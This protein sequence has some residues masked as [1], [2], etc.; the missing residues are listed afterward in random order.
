MRNSVKIT[1][2]PAWL[3]AP[4]VR[5]IFDALGAPEVD[6]RAVGGAV[7]DTVMGRDRVDSEIDIA[8]PEVPDE[9]IARLQSAKLKVVPTGLSHGTV[10]AVVNG[11][12]FE[13]TSLRR[14]TATDGR[15]AVVEFTEDWHEDARRRDFTFNA[16][17]MDAD[18]VVHDDH[19]GVEDAKAGRVRFVGNASD[20]IQEDYLRVLR[21]FRFQALYGRAPIDAE[22]LAACGAN[23]G[24]L[25]HLSAERVQAELAKML[26]APSPYESVAQMQA[27]GV[28]RAVLPVRDDAQRFARLQ[29]IERDAAIADH[30]WLRRLAALIAPDDAD[31]VADHLKLS[32]AD[33]ALLL[34]LCAPA[35][36][37]GPETPPA[38]RARALHELGAALV[39]DRAL[40]AWAAQPNPSAESWRALLAAIAGWTPKPLPVGGA[41]VLALG[42]TPGPRVGA[43]LEEMLA[44][45]LAQDRAPDRA[46]ALAE[47]K[48]RLSKQ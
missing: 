35:P 47:L 42:V 17:S 28:L 27:T 4:E 34:R 14:D 16:M 15:H 43:V 3:Q 40:L 5:R 32:N 9:V 38:V 1:L 33:R 45:W 8:T 36:I 6:V 39:R 48:S 22:T 13:I 7:R 26:G 24:G 19:G 31:P 44:W 25:A 41:D 23:V 12:P 10:T 2:T 46:A 20:R 37:L 21:L 30:G 29:Q 18:G 11:R